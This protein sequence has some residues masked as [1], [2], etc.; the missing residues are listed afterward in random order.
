MQF[1]CHGN[2][3]TKYHLSTW[4]IHAHDL[5]YSG[6]LPESG[7]DTKKEPVIASPPHAGKVQVLLLCDVILP[8]LFTGMRVDHPERIAIRCRQVSAIGG[9]P[10]LRRHLAR[11]ILVEV[12]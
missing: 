5:P 1:G 12:R 4:A 2:A 8:N 11:S 9:K 7:G 3:C 6:F 10:E